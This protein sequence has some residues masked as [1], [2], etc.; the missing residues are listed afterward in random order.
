MT[1][2]TLG[3]DVTTTT[4]TL[5]NLAD[6]L[7]SRRIIRPGEGA[8][9]L[10]LIELILRHLNRPHMAAYVTE[11]VT[12][13]YLVVDFLLNYE[14]SLLTDQVCTLGKQLWNF[15]EG[16]FYIGSKKR[17]T[18]VRF[19]I[20]NVKKISRKYIFKHSDNFFLYLPKQS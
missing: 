16:E 2:L 17:G 3:Y 12:P 8:K 20:F 5:Q 18:Q 14:D 6:V 13:F 10:E 19:A 4:A 15:F 9:I 1:L 7:S 11:S